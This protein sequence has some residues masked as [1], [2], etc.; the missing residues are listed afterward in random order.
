MISTRKLGCPCHWSVWNLTN[1]AIIGS[2]KYECLTVYESV[3]PSN[4]CSAPWRHKI[5]QTIEIASIV[6]SLKKKPAGQ[7]H[8]SRILNYWAATFTPFHRCKG[9]MAH[10]TVLVLCQTSS[11]S[12]HLAT[13][14]HAEPETGNFTEFEIF[15]GSLTLP[16][17]E[18]TYE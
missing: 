4:T 2:S 17:Q 3:L 15:D 5:H 6:E 8:R 16:L 12:V 1:L 14:T 9:N 13:A 11:S 10:K 7:L 18:S